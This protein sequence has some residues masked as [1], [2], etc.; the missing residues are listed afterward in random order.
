M[1]APE[2]YE[3]PVRQPGGMLWPAQIGERPWLLNPRH[4][5]S[6]AAFHI[7]RLWAR[8]R[9]GMG[10]SGPLPEPGGINQQ[11]NWLMAAFGV[12]NGKAAE[13]EEAARTAR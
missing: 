13:I 12:L 1:R 6:P 4:C 7:V 11:P 9:G 5:I 2:L 3:G 8:T 10:G